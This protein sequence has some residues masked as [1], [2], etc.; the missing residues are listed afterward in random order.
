VRDWCIDLLT[1]HQLAHKMHWDAERNYKFN[2]KR[3]ERFYDEP[4]TGEAWWDKQVDTFIYILSII[5]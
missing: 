4:W 5:I 3:F 2:D 1:K